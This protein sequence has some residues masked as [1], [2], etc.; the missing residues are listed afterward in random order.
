MKSSEYQRNFAVKVADMRRKVLNNIFIISS[1]GSYRDNSYVHNNRLGNNTTNNYNSSVI[2]N[3]CTA[4][5][6]TSSDAKLSGCCRLFPDSSREQDIQINAGPASRNNHSNNAPGVHA[7]LN[8]PLSFSNYNCP[9]A[10]ADSSSRRCRL[11]TG[12]SLCCALRT[13]CWSVVMYLRACFMPSAK[14]LQALKSK[15]SSLVFLLL[16]SLHVNIIL[17]EKVSSSNNEQRYDHVLRKSTN[18]I[19]G[20]D[21]DPMTTNRVTNPDFVDFFNSLSERSGQNWTSR[22][23]ESDI[24]DFSESPGSHDTSSKHKRGSKEIVRKHRVMEV[25][26]GK[27]S[28]AKNGRVHGGHSPSESDGVHGGHSPAKSDGVHG[29][30]SPA[31]SDGVHGGHKAKSGATAPAGKHFAWKS[32]WQNGRKIPVLS[33]EPDGQRDRRSLAFRLQSYLHHRPRHNRSH[34]KITSSSDQSHSEHLQ[35]SESQDKMVGIPSGHHRGSS[36]KISS[37]HHDGSSMKIPWNHSQAGNTGTSDG[38]VRERRAK[39]S[40]R[41]LHSNRKRKRHPDI[42]YS[43][44][45]VQDSVAIDAYSGRGGRGSRERSTSFAGVDRH[46]RTGYTQEFTQ[47][48][49]IL[50][51]NEENFIEDKL[52]S[53]AMLGPKSGALTLRKKHNQDLEL[54]HGELT[55]GLVQEKNSLREEMMK[56]SNL[57]AERKMIVEDMEAI[58]EDIEEILERERRS[59]QF[60][61]E[62]I[63]KRRE[64][65]KLRKE[66]RRRRMMMRKRERQRNNAIRSQENQGTVNEEL[67][68]GLEFLEAE[69]KRMREE[70]RRKRI[71]RRRE[72]RRERRLRRRL[73]KRNKFKNN[74]KETNVVIDIV[75]FEQDSTNELHGHNACQYKDLLKCARETGLVAHSTSSRYSLQTAPRCLQRKVS[76]PSH[77]V[78]QVRIADRANVSS[79][80]SEQWSVTNLLAAM[81][82]QS[83]SHDILSNAPLPLH[84]LGPG[85]QLSSGGSNAAVNSSSS[86]SVLRKGVGSGQN[87]KPS[88]GREFVCG[89][90]AAVINIACT[91]PMNKIMFRQMLHGVST[92]RAVNQLKAEGLK[93]LYRGILP[94][95]CQKSL[96]TSIM[97]GMYDQYSRAFRSFAPNMPSSAVMGTSAMLAGITEALLCPFERIQ[98]LMQDKNFHDKYKNTGHCFRELRAHGVQE[99]Y[100]GLAL[101][102]LRNGASNIMFFG[103]RGPIKEQF[104]CW[105]KE[106][107]WGEVASNFMSG[108]VLGA[109]ISTVMY[110]VNVLKTQQQVR[111]GGTFVSVRQTATDI[112]RER[113]FKIFHGIHVNY[114]RALVSWGII[115]AS[116][117]MLLRVWYSS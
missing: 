63:L 21:D 78:Y 15:Y 72:K 24:T 70:R 29:G 28:P 16:L 11:N 10:S 93:T 56:L 42:T 99:Y 31:K 94:P 87:L 34:G 88:D 102:L 50:D 77:L 82:K 95:L 39:P 27:H 23:L 13:G 30:H 66:K 108:A 101:V 71:A 100:R 5:T 65:R 111:V 51:Q 8:I 60:R 32:A 38:D 112:F 97:F 57:D 54:N 44:N 64:R 2:K 61:R 80:K 86:G 107:W 98:T 84:A 6:T 117:E 12:S 53:S 45:P 74:S 110:P 96:S 62:K 81:V 25:T 41:E 17:A 22:A 113:G 46:K 90:G 114:S 109:F 105:T 115:N 79:K 52:V 104:Q 4:A 83:E 49:K 18:F 116:Y 20:F 9:W 47:H 35:T 67:A 91:F 48:E 58:E 73:R 89:W 85:S 68:I 36:T 103:L 69:R 26:H 106:E 1:N 7:A 40:L 43:G 92:K 14:S 75:Q 3:T 19:D 76:L 55:A 37:S 33:I 59:L